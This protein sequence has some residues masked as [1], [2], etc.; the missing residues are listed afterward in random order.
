[1]KSGK[2]TLPR[3]PG[4]PSNIVDE[5]AGTESESDEEAAL[6]LGNAKDVDA[7][8]ELTTINTR[9]LSDNIP[10]LIRQ[11]LLDNSSL[12]ITSS[13]EKL[14]L[15]DGV[16]NVESVDDN[17]T[18]ETSS[19]AISVLP[20]IRRIAFSGFVVVCPPT[21][22]SRALAGVLPTGPSALPDTFL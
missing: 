18:I 1:M 21:P 22:L 6:K 3:R 7:K 11:L 9:L 19:R 20:R 17:T 5:V 12:S 4:R 2:C 15:F 8:C 13:L 14:P 10:I 16:L